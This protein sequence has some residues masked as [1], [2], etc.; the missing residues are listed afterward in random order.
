[1]NDLAMITSTIFL[2][3]KNPLYS[4]LPDVV[5]PVGKQITKFHALTDIVGFLDEDVRTRA[6]KKLRNSNKKAVTALEKIKMQ[7]CQT[8]PEPN[9]KTLIECS[10]DMNSIS[11]QLHMERDALTKVQLPIGRGSEQ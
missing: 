4:L 5:G 1:M 11:Y 2:T 6:V 7:L 3:T 9:F 10:A 8:S